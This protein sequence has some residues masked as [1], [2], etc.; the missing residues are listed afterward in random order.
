MS[1]PHKITDIEQRTLWELDYDKQKKSFST[2]YVR[3]MCV[4]QYESI[5]AG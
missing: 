3:F 4:E 5:F 2:A 1:S